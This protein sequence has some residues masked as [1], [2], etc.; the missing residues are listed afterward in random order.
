MSK[1]AYGI[2]DVVLEPLREVWR[3]SRLRINNSLDNKNR[4]YAKHESKCFHNSSLKA[5][6]RI[7]RIHMF[8]DLPDPDQL[9]KDMDPD[10]DPS[11]SKQKQ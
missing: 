2:G 10:P 7:D 8:L 6:F 1:G 9:A 11:V 3:T 5:V 4:P